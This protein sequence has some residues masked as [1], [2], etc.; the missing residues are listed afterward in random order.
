MNTKE[1]NNMLSDED[2]DKVNGGIAYFDRDSVKFKFQPPYDY[3]VK[4]QVFQ[5]SGNQEFI[6]TIIGTDIGVSP[7]RNDP[8][9]FPR[10]LVM[11]DGGDHAVQVSEH[12]MIR[13]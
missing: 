1:L 3:K 11:P 8:Y 13:I 10:Y 5:M 12:N 2:L 6:G 9:Y 4:C 7:D